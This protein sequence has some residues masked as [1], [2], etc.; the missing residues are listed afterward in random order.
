MTSEPYV[1]Y[2]NRK[3]NYMPSILK[4]LISLLLLIFFL[5]Y[6][7]SSVTYYA[8]HDLFNFRRRDTRVLV[9]LGRRDTVRLPRGRSEETFSALLPLH[10]AGA[11]G[12]REAVKWAGRYRQAKA[13]VERASERLMKPRRFRRVRQAGRVRSRSRTLTLMACINN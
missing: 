4:R 11:D 1:L 3:I 13:Q 7:A 2:E 10:E 6:S 12:S 5:L 8:D 9:A